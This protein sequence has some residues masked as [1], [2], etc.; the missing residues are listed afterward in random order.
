MLS[1]WHPKLKPSVNSKF[2]AVP[3]GRFP[4]E[5]GWLPAWRKDRKFVVRRLV[6]ALRLGQ[7]YC[8]LLMWKV[9]PVSVRERGLV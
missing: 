3:A 6:F 5:G 2:A 4:G 7:A 9:S 8:V 1:L